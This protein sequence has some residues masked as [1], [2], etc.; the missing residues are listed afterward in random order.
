MT[1]QFINEMNMFRGKQKV[2]M[3]NNICIVDNKKFIFHHN[4]LPIINITNNIIDILLMK[5]YSEYVINTKLIKYHF[6]KRYS[7]FF[8]IY[9][10]L[11]EGVLKGVH[12]F[13]INNIRDLK[14][15]NLVEEGTNIYILEKL[16]KI[17]KIQFTHE[18]IKEFCGNDKENNGLGNEFVFELI[19]DSADPTQNIF[20]FLFYQKIDISKFEIYFCFINVEDVGELLQNKNE[21]R[22]IELIN[23]I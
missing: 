5:L 12:F 7:I 1:N 10:Y 4:F 8:F 19:R 20:P 23:L 6:S 18:K 15:E 17:Y 14:K 16:D 3:S 22:E 11:D 13:L 21:D 2:A 9:R